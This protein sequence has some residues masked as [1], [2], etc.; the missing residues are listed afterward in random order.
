MATKEVKKNATVGA[1]NKNLS[2][3]TTTTSQEV[4]LVPKTAEEVPKFIAILEEQLKELRGNVETSVSLDI[5]FDGV[6]IKNVKT[7][8]DLLDIS[9]LIHAQHEAYLTEVKRY[10]LDTAKL[11]EYT[12]EN[13]TVAHW[14]KVIE[15]ALFELVNS[16]KIKQLESAISKLSENLTAK[17]KLERDLKEIF[18][19]AT[20]PLL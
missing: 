11:K 20:T 10:K 1:K 5:T 6:N 4:S 2:T 14:E 13:K 17:T 12:I 9:G 3:D 19:S 8:R 16:V 7:L 15:K 18:E